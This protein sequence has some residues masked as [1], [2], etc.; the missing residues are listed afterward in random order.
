MYKNDR[1]NKRNFIILS[2]KVNNKKK[3]SIIYYI[4]NLK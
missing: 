3:T 4:K 2:Y 1:R